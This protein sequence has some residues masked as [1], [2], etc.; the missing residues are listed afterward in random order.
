MFSSPCFP[1]YLGSYAPPKFSK[2]TW[3]ESSTVQI[4]E[5]RPAHQ[6]HPTLFAGNQNNYQ[7]YPRPSMHGVL[8]TFTIKINQ[9]YLK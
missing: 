1:Q 5:L 7:S 3:V 8:P 4:C 6:T 9:M 2:S